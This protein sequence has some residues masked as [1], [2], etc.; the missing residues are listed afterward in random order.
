[1][2]FCLFFVLFFLNSQTNCYILK[3]SSQ[4]LIWWCYLKLKEV[5]LINENE[6]NK[7]W[8]GISRCWIWYKFTKFVL[9]CKCFQKCSSRFCFVF[10]L[11]WWDLILNSNRIMVIWEIVESILM[12]TSSKSESFQI[13]Y[14]LDFGACVFCQCI[15]YNF[16]KKL[17]NQLRFQYSLRFHK[18]TSPTL[19]N[20]C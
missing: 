17:Y 11:P 16:V 19:R 4:W 7:G 9:W 14:F 8:E 10:F 18:F 12:K 3:S 20:I 1:M 2:F 6:I 5:L 15:S 13:G